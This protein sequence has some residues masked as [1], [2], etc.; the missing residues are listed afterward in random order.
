MTLPHDTARCH[1]AACP[2]RR[3][4][5]RWIERHGGTDHTLQVATLRITAEPCP[6]LIPRD[7]LQETS[8]AG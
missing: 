3:Q 5:L 6:H 2:Q 1:D 8:P 7:H 4:C